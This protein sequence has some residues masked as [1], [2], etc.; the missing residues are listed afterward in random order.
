MLDLPN[1][2][3]WDFWLADDLTSYHAF[4][5]KA[6]RALGEPDLRHRNASVGHAVSTDLVT[7]RILDDALAPAQRPAFDDL[8][9]WTGSVVRDG[10][11][12]WRMFYTGL[13]MSD[14]GLV[15]RIGCARSEDLVH[16]HRGPTS[17]LGEADPR[18]YEKL[19]SASWP[20]ESWRDPWIVR[21]ASG[22]WHAYVTARAGGAGSGL[23]VIG[24]AASSDLESWQV[25]PPLSEP[26]SG[27]EWLEVISLAEVDGRWVLMFSCLAAEMVD[28]AAGGGG[29]WTVAVDGPGARVEVQR[30]VRL[31]SEDL[32][33]GKLVRDRT[34]RWLLLAFRNRD[35]SGTF[36]GGVIDPVPVAWNEAGTGLVMVGG[37]PSWHP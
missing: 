25:G 5:L 26:G 36:T 21:D 12:L 16:W 20:D 18:F 8:A 37:A 10:A 27:F 34:G 7:W 17:G 9:I 29:I 4:F 19:G 13:S 33:V 22:R 2:W 30:A 6:P 14:D 28:S 15:Q 35:A 1:D 32:Y 23:G 24:H 31:T 11:G 3:V